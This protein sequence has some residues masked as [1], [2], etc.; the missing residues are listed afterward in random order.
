M[1]AEKIKYTVPILKELTQNLD[2]GLEFI[3]IE[4]PGKVLIIN[5]PH[6]D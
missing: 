1:E 3:R 2:R 5:I 4:A 6:K